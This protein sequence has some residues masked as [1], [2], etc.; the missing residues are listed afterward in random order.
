MKASNGPVAASRF[1]QATSK[2]KHDHVVRNLA[3]TG[4]R[5]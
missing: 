4:V 3:A 5:K 2:K 1:V